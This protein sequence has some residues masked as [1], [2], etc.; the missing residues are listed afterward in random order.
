MTHKELPQQPTRAAIQSLLEVA[1]SGNRQAT[2]TQV[3]VSEC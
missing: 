3:I 2:M 1:G